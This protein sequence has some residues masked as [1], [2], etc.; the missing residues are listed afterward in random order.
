MKKFMDYCK[1]KE[2]NK[3]IEAEVFICA[4]IER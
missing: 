2:Q 3:Y 1:H 4:Y